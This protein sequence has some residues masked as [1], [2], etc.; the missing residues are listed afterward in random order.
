MDA[1]WSLVGGFAVALRPA[2]LLFALRR[3]RHRHRGRGPARH[4]P[5][6]R[7]RDPPSALLQPRRDGRHHHALGDLLRRHVRRHHHHRAHARPR[8][9]SL[10]GDRDRR[11]RDGQAG[12]GRRGPGHRRD[13][14]V[15]RRH[16]RHPGPGRRGAAPRPGG[17]LVRAAGVLRPDGARADPGRR[18]VGGLPRHRAPQRALR[19]GAGGPRRGPRRGHAAADLRGRRP[20]RRH[21]LRA[22]HHG[23]LRDRRDPRQSRRE[24][25]ADRDGA[26]PLE[27]AHPAGLGRLRDAHRAGHRNRHRARPDPGHRD[28]LAHDRLVRGREAGLPAPRAVRRAAPSRASPA[29][30]PP[31]TPTRTRRSSP[32]SRSAS[33]PP[34]RSRSCS[35]P[36]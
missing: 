19:P 6:R 33:P 20:P 9:G 5:D 23:A 21:Q 25:G 3:Q 16:R 8:R 27:D 15:H 28:H 29:R 36:S 22:G 32:S 13:R 17:A 30:R 4:R 18:P 1:L 35:A 2:N 14:L 12:P 24:E 7:D 34:R 10:R 26:D 31:T 11:L